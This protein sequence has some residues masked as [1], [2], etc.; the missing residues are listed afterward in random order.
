MELYTPFL[1]SGY[2]EDSITGE[3][4][5]AS[6]FLYFA[7]CEP[8]KI[9]GLFPKQN[10]DSISWVSRGLYPLDAKYIKSE[11][12]YGVYD[13]LSSFGGSLK[14]GKDTNGLLD[15][16]K[17]SSADLNGKV[18]TI[19][20]AVSNFK[21][22]KE[23]ET[24]AG[25]LIEGY[26]NMEDALKL[27]DRDLLKDISVKSESYK[28][29]LTGDV[30]G[31]EA[32]LSKIG[33][34]VEQEIE[35]LKKICSLDDENFKDSISERNKIYD[36]FKD[37]I[38]EKDKIV[39]LSLANLIVERGTKKREVDRLYGDR[40]AYLNQDYILNKNKYDIARIYG[41][42]FD[43]DVYE[44][45]MND[46]SSRID[47][48]RAE[49]AEEIRKIEKYYD[50]LID[51]EKNKIKEIIHQRDSRI[52]ECQNLHSEFH[53]VIES[54]KLLLSNDIFDKKK[55][56][57]E[58]R[59]WLIRISNAGED[60][61]VKILVPYY[62]AEFKGSD[63][64]YRLFFPQVLKGK[65]QFKSLISGITGKTVLPFDSREG[66]FE[67]LLKNFRDWLKLE[68][69]KCLFSEFQSN[70][71]ITMD[72]TYDKVEKGLSSLFVN[73]YISD[74]SFDRVI[75]IIKPVFD[76]K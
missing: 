16:E 68:E 8:E 67:E 21:N 55:G 23:G 9:I 66:I 12:L 45:N 47:Q 35:M 61:P 39:G 14:A 53:S 1:V 3:M 62:I 63:T 48:I 27:W 4:E 51:E 11:G 43:M 73:G 29:L 49:G 18:K 36:E 15:F 59:S 22:L 19:K 76:Q 58:I 32:V 37:K 75:N 57:G 7:Y 33:V 54:L 25:S 6:A 74:K 13:C 26:K 64:K 60:E 56:T 38:M 44:K 70:N 42:E 2:S 34:L 50:G 10:K 20:A 72:G 65:N 41:N 17:L 46:S 24:E 28:N 69:N 52:E 31:V 30:S 5:I 40:E 71:L